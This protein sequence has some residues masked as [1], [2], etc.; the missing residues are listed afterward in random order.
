MDLAEFPAWEGAAETKRRILQEHKADEFM[1]YITDEYPEGISKG[2]LNDLLWFSR[3]DVYYML[4]ISDDAA[5]EEYDDGGADD[6]L[7]YG[8]DDEYNGDYLDDFDDFLE[9]FGEDDSVRI[10]DVW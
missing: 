1:R 6:Y 10:D 4:G 9:D 7:G 2:D 8:D 5:D 3:K